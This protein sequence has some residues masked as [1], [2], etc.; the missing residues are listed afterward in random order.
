MITPDLIIT[1]AA[2]AWSSTREELLGDSR[3][4]HHVRARRLAMALLREIFVLSHEAIS[5][6]CGGKSRDTSRSA[7]HEMERRVR[8]PG[9]RE[10]WRVEVRIFNALKLRFQMQMVADAQPTA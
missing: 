2:T 3:V 4:G 1:E 5:D 6:I 8:K 10:D 9:L 7:C